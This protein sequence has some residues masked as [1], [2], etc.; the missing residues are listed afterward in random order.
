MSDEVQVAM[1]RLRRHEC[2]ARLPHDPRGAMLCVLGRLAATQQNLAVPL[3]AEERTMLR[4]AA[5]QIKAQD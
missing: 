4:A 1:A 3:L 2:Y 5:D